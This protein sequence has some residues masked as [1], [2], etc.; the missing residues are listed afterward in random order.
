MDARYAIE[1]DK[2]FA[3][4]SV[5]VGA[6]FFDCVRLEVV[7]ARAN[8]ALR[9]HVGRVPCLLAVRP[10]GEIVKSIRKLSAAG[11]FVAMRT[12]LSKDYTNRLDRAVKEQRAILKEQAKLE[13]DR[14]KLAR[15]E[16]KELAAAELQLRGKEKA[17]ADRESALYRL[18]P[19]KKA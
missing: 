13:R 18:A 11:V 17:L 12:T 5:V 2:A 9:P 14:G 10:N 15:L 1:S 8:V 4:E 19:K 7:R 3:D 16:G 6:R